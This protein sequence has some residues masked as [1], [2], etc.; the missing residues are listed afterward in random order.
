MSNM[1]DSNDILSKKFHEYYSNNLEKT[2]IMLVSEL[3]NTSHENNKLQLI[4]MRRSIIC[5]KRWTKFDK[6][7][8]TFGNFSNEQKDRLERYCGYD[9]FS[10][11]CFMYDGDY[12]PRL[13]FL[14]HDAY[15]YIA[16]NCQEFD[17][18]SLVISGD[19]LIG[20][21][22]YIYKL[23]SDTYYNDNQ[24]LHDYFYQKE[25][26]STKINKIFTGKR[27]RVIYTDIAMFMIDNI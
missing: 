16:F 15:R 18:I 9:K 21:G 13:F 8:Y 11:T 27:S 14:L 17:N 12:T 1:T 6:T 22:L 4:D 2:R 20:K 19:M 26:L 24:G 25:E 3:S 23:N 5:D 10:R 7:C